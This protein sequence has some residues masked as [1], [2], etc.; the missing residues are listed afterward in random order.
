MMSGPMDPSRQ[1]PS[2]MSGM[3]P[4]MNPPRPGMGPL[5]PSYG[6]GM[7]GPPPGGMPPISMAGQGQGRPQWAPNNNAVSFHHY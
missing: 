2:G 4:R 1:G 3:G 7:R 5:G 6:P